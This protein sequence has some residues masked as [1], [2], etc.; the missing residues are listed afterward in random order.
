M[1]EDDDGDYQRT[2]GMGVKIIVPTWLRRTDKNAD[3]PW[4]VERSATTWQVVQIGVNGS[5]IAPVVQ[6]DTAEAAMAYA[7]MLDAQENMP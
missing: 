4:G 5:P 2:L 6:F 1:I 3:F 7:V